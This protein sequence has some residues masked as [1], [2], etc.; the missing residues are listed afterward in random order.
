MRRNIKTVIT[1]ALACSTLLLCIAP[2]ASASESGPSILYQGPANGASNGHLGTNEFMDLAYGSDGSNLY[3]LQNSTGIEKIATDTIISGE[4]STTTITDYNLPSASGLPVMAISPG[5]QFAYAAGKSTCAVYKFN[6]ATPGDVS[7][8]PVTSTDASIGGW[9]TINLT[10]NGEYLMIFSD[11][12]H[13]IYKIN[14]TTNEVVASIENA[15]FFCLSTVA[16][17]TTLFMFN[18]CSGRFFEIN[19]ASFTVTHDY[20]LTAWSA[21]WNHLSLVEGNIY[22]GYVGQVT[23]LNTVTHALTNITVENVNAELLQ[24]KVTPGG[25]YGWFLD[26]DISLTVKKVALTGINAGKIFYSSAFPTGNTTGSA[27]TM[28][29]TGSQIA[30]TSQ[31]GVLGN[32][33]TLITDQ[34][35]V[36]VEVPP[37]S[38]VT[39]SP[40]ETRAKAEIARTRAVESAKTEIKSTLISGKPLTLEQFQSADIQGVT[41]KNASAINAEIALLAEDKKSDIA[42]VMQVVLKF[43]TVDKVA[44]HETFYAADLVAVGLVPADSKSKTTILNALKKLSADQLDSYQEIQSAIAAVEKKLADRKVALDAVRARIKARA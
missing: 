21:S 24:L 36:S 34:P 8:L 15:A 30:Y 1:F 4:T 5:G 14:T 7:C 39:E 42:A 10:P 43:A 27:L 44:N 11:G 37:T 41:A 20:A 6:L 35:D 25:K 32:Q 16:T 28:N 26:A 22:F 9:E 23:I 38:V 13:K 29:S 2:S 31:G 17:N 40:E 33:L 19:I 18:N 12:N 3:L